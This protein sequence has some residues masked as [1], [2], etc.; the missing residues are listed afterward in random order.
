MKSEQL[1]FFVNCELYTPEIGHRLLV[2]AL[3]YSDFEG[4]KILARV[5]DLNNFREHNLPLLH[6]V[7]KQMD[8]FG[9]GNHMGI[10]ECFLSAGADPNILDD[11]GSTPLPSGIK[12]FK[13]LLNYGMVPIF[14]NKPMLDY[15]TDECPENLK[16]YIDAIIDHQGLD[17]KN[18]LD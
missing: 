13:L 14:K 9:R 3:Y 15:N 12:T 1:Q 2:S 11:N 6:F 7:L 8:H 10:I 18:A 5:I 4:C 16:L 17:I